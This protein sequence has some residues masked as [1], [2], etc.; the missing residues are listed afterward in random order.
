M[1]VR[2][3]K[4]HLVQLCGVLFVVA[5][6]IS[7]GTLPVDSQSLPSEGNQGRTEYRFV[8]SPGSDF[9]AIRLHFQGANYVTLDGDGN[10]ALIAGSEQVIQY[11]PLVYQEE[12][13]LRQEIAANYVLTGTDQA[14]IQFAGDYDS[15]KPLIIAIRFSSEVVTVRD[16]IGSPSEDTLVVRIDD[17][18]LS[19]SPV[20][21]SAAVGIAAITAPTAAPTGV[22]ATPDNAAGTVKWTPVPPASNGGSPITGYRIE[23]SAAC[24]APCTPPFVKNV[25]RPESAPHEAVVDGLTNGSTYIFKVF[26]RNSVGFGPGS[27]PVNATP[28]ATLPGAPASATATGANASAFVNWTEPLNNGGSPITAYIVNTLVG[29]GLQRSDRLGANVRSVLITQLANGT[30]YSFEI[31][32]VNNVGEGAPFTPLPSATPN[33][34]APAAPTQVIA[35]R[36][37][38]EVSLQW[39][40]PAD[41][42]GSPIVSWKIVIIAVGSTTPTTHFIPDT[43]GD[44]IRTT[45]IA[46]LTNGTTYTFDVSGGNCTAPGSDLACNSTAGINYGPAGTSNAVTPATVPDSPRTLQATPRHNSAILTWIV[47]VSNG[48]DALTGYRLSIA[49]FIQ[50]YPVT[51]APGDTRFT[52]TGLTNGTE[53]TFSLVAFNTVGSSV[54]PATVKVTPTTTV[55]AVPTAVT[56]TRGSKQVTVSWTAPTDTGGFPIAGYRISIACTSPPPAGTTCTN[57]NPAVVE[58]AGTATSYT[59][60][61]LVNGSSY[62]FKVAARNTGVVGYGPEAT[63]SPVTPATIPGVPTG[64]GRTLG[65]ASVTVSWVAPLDNG[66]DPLTSFRISVFANGVFL[67]EANPGAS[68][69]SFL[70]DGLTNDGTVYTFFVAAV[71]TVGL[72]TPDQSP[73]PAR[74]GP[75]FSLSATS[76]AYGD[77]NLGTPVGPDTTRTITV[78]NIGSSDL[79]IDILETTA[80]A[81]FSFITDTCKRNRFAPGTT[82]TAELNFSPVLA[83]PISGVFRI[84]SDAIGGTDTTTTPPNPTIALSGTGVGPTVQ[85][86]P[87]SLAYGNQTVGTASPIKTMEIKN[88]GNRNLQINSVSIAGF[89]APNYVV[90][91][92]SDFCS[93]RL[94]IP[95]QACNVGIRFVP[96][97]GGAADATV[98]AEHDA[99]FKPAQV[100]LSGNGLV[101]QPKAPFDVVATSAAVGQAT[102]TWAEP[103]S[104]GGMP[105]LRYKVEA[106][107]LDE[108]AGTMTLHRTIFVDGTDTVPPATTAT[109]SGLNGLTSGR[110]YVFRVAAG[111]KTGPNGTIAF[112]PFAESD[113]VPVL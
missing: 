66:G 45:R 94:L 96:I 56:A 84:L 1:H 33:P 60:T 100:T 85:F 87:A 52:A 49:P 12:D 43:G 14:S 113:S 109:F 27:T 68:A 25:D 59:W 101:T 99:F 32:A 102:V 29:D 46:G 3:Q 79:N 23:V 64:L 108:D 88:T 104:N 67:R 30:L 112:G 110:K 83:G 11:K 80:P 8:V 95:N 17:N 89:G 86:T 48:G 111:N 26:A 22:T 4:N 47:P 65:D 97:R 73:L 72:S 39:R 58:P 55:P 5:G 103:D 31:K 37:N 36:G 71:N 51:I 54:T 16:A 7:F 34:T 77:V 81:H 41:N 106:L 28:L 69:T 82:C 92:P 18:L 24:T 98:S 62:T 107:L 61:G 44:V 40:L 13:G 57:P 10:L 9:N 38:Q 50:G 93:S 74:P 53:Y 90:D 78:T 20:A 63:S 19:G 6:I 76:L 105:I 70:V 21:A 35:S 15:A 42:G 2:R 75:R 91:Q